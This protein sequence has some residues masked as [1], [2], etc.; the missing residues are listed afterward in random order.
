[1]DKAVVESAFQNE[2]LYDV[3]FAVAGTAAA[4]ATTAVTAG[5]ID[6]VKYTVL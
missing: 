5:I 4:G 3:T 2:D 1:M 6:T